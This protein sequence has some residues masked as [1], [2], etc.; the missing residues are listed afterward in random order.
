MLQKMS[1]EGNVDDYIE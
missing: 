1:S